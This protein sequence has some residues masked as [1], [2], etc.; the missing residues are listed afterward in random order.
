MSNT[1]KIVPQLHPL[2]LVSKVFYQ[3]LVDYPTHPQNPGDGPSVADTVIAA[4][5][6]AL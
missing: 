5:I 4:S 2:Q 1:T 6:G 3:E